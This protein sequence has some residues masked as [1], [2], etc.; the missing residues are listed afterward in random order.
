MTSFGDK[1]DVV[2]KVTLTLYRLSRSVSRNTSASCALE[3]KPSTRST[4]V[5]DP[6]LLH[7]RMS[8]VTTFITKHTISE[9]TFC[10]KH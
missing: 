2:K 6:W 9:A 1:S 5:S 3:A 10:L 4:N 7:K 8:V